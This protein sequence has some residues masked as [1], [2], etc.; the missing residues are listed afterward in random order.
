[1]SAGHGRGSEE[2]GRGSRFYKFVGG[3]VVALVVAVVVLPL[4]FGGEQPNE[5]RVVEIQPGE[6]DSEGGDA[7]GTNGESDPSGGDA[8][9]HPLGEEEGGDAGEGDDG[10]EKWWRAAEEGDEPSSNDSPAA[11]L[12][13]VLPDS[14][15]EGSEGDRGQ[16]EA[17][18]EGEAE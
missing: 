10:Q 15:N 16:A 12:E 18:D 4:W 13:R 2:G 5:A 6:A 14:A 8:V 3:L 17:S 1:M 11:T 7:P 9:T